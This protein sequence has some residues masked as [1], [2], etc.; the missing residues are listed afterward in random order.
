MAETPPSAS[1]PTTPTKSSALANWLP[2]SRAPT[3]SNEDQTAAEKDKTI[4]LVSDPV[5]RKYAQSVDRSLNAFLDVQEW[6]D[7][8]AFLAKLLKSIQSF[9]QYNEIPHKLIVSKRL[10]QCLNPALPTGVHQKALE[11][12]DKIFIIIGFEGLQRDLQ[13]WSA[14]L[15]PF[16]QYAAMSVRPAVLELYKSHYFPL[17]ANLRSI[18]KSITLSLLPGLEEETGDFFDEVLSMLDYLSNTVSPDYFL[19]NISLILLTSP[20]S[21]IPAL[22]YLIRKM[23]TLSTDEDV[24]FHLNSD[25]NILVRGISSSLIDTDMFVRRSALDLLNSAL[26]INGLILQKYSKKDF[27]VD[28]SRN[29]CN[30]VLRRDISLTRRLYSWLLGSSDVKEVQSEHFEKF[31]LP[32]IRIWMLSDMNSTKSFDSRPYKIFISLL[33]KWEIGNNLTENVITEI[34]RSLKYHLENE[35]DS[36]DVKIITSMVL[37]T[38]DIRLLWKA[39]NEQITVEYGGQ[40]DLFESIDLTSMIIDNISPKD[41]EHARLHFPVQLVNSLNLAYTDQQSENSK[42]SLLEHTLYLTQKLISHIPDDVFGKNA[43]LVKDG[44]H[45]TSDWE[46]IAKAYYTSN[47]HIPQVDTPDTLYEASFRLLILITSSWGQE[48]SDTSAVKVSYDTLYKL[49]HLRKSDKILSGKC[50]ELIS[51]WFE[52]AMKFISISKDFETLKSLIECILIIREAGLEEDEMYLKW[53]NREAH[54]TLLKSLLNHINQENPTN[55]SSVVAL[56]QDIEKTTSRKHISSLLSSRLYDNNLSARMEAVEQF[57]IIYNLVESSDIPVLDVTVPVSKFFSYQTFGNA[58]EMQVNAVW[59]KNNFKSS[60]QLAST[61]IFNVSKV[62]QYMKLVK[63]SDVHGSEVECYE[64]FQNFDQ[65]IVIYSLQQL[66]K[67]S[68]HSGTAFWRQ[69]NTEKQDVLLFEQLLKLLK[70]EPSEIIKETLQPG[71]KDVQMASMRLLIELISNCSMASDKYMAAAITISNYLNYHLHFNN[72]D[73]QPKAIELLT[74][75]LEHFDFND[76]DDVKDLGS[77]VIK[78]LHG[79]ISTASSQM[80]LRHWLDMTVLLVE[81]YPSLIRNHK[82]EAGYIVCDKLGNMLDT[83]DLSENIPSQNDLSSILAALD[84]ILTFNLD[85][86]YSSSSTSHDITIINQTMKL[87]RSTFRRYT[88]LYF[89]LQDRKNNI[90][91]ML[92]AQCQ[93]NIFN[94]FDKRPSEMVDLAV[95]HHHQENNVSALLEL[96]KLFSDKPRLLV[97]IFCR[98]VGLKTFAGHEKPRSMWLSDAVTHLQLFQSLETY[99]DT[100]D[101]KDAL[102]SWVALQPFARESIMSTLTAQ[103][104][105]CIYPT[106]RCLY[107]FGVQVFVAQSSLIIEKRVHQ[108]YQDILQRFVESCILLSS[109]TSDTGTWAL[110]KALAGLDVTNVTGNSDFAD[111]TT[112]K[113]DEVDDNSFN[114]NMIEIHTFI[115]KELLVNISKL[116]T[117][118][119][120]LQSI[121]NNVSYY[122]VAPVLK[123]R[124]KNF[125]STSPLI[126]DMLTEMTKLPHCSRSWR[127]L[128]SDVFYDNKFFTTSASS[129]WKYL[130]NALMST[131]KDKFADLVSRVSSAPSTNIFANREYESLTRALNL[132]RLSFAIYA[133]DP[134]SYMSQLT[135]VKENAI[136]DHQGGIIDQIS[137]LFGNQEKFDGQ[138][139]PQLENTQRQPLLLN[140]KRIESVQ[141]LQPFFS[142]V[143]HV[144]FNNVIDKQ[145]VDWKLLDRTIG[146][147]DNDPDLYGIEY[148]S[149]PSGMHLMESDE[150][151]FTTRD[152]NHG[153][154][155]YRKISSTEEQERGV[156]MFS[157][158]LITSDTYVPYNYLP[159]LEELSLYLMTNPPS[160]DLPVMF[161]APIQSSDYSKIIQQS[162]SPKALAFLLDLLG[163]LL[164]LLFRFLLARK[165]VV[166]FFRPTEGRG[167]GW[168]STAL[169]TLAKILNEVDDGVSN[170]TRTN[171]IGNIGLIDLDRLKDIEGGF[172]ASTTD[173]LLLE[174][175][176]VYDAIIDLSPKVKYPSLYISQKQGNEMLVKRQTYTLGDLYI[177]RQLRS[178]IDSQ[179]LVSS[180]PYGL[181]DLIAD[182]WSSLFGIKNSIHIPSPASSDYH[183]ENED[184]DEDDDEEVRLFGKALNPTPAIT[185]FMKSYSNAILASLL[186]LTLKPDHDY[187][188][189]GNVR[190]DDHTHHNEG[191]EGEED[192]PLELTAK[193]NLEDRAR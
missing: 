168:I 177:W 11:I 166:V 162:P 146:A 46:S 24:I 92:I 105:A 159:E 180:P 68:E 21:R 16:F 193:V 94:L 110:R 128:V 121:A 69:L 120:K 101:V 103:R 57:G 10:S 102:Q 56:M 133:G 5:Y 165:R 78:L 34:I 106:L 9:T 1:T 38:V 19:Q 71:S 104:K 169:D 97:H 136:G 191:E 89:A 72:L 26:S 58:D 150:I 116:I 192:S 75:T 22:N 185:S 66:L 3:I 113:A 182:I 122:I 125:N 14:G 43:S 93:Q 79:A 183:E 70:T 98:N 119:E 13:M 39:M 51:G 124:S 155:I 54:E 74:A 181:I 144:T 12:Y 127:G 158:G 53:M 90:Y 49:I 126:V 154:A 145:E 149:M 96:L 138:F 48:L 31:S 73:V 175:P 147:N 170:Q 167:V 32:L 62:D 36:A 163:P 7:F 50:R 88:K 85:D 23:P 157:V 132:R 59:L 115:A 83:L 129:Q 156:K 6:A 2:R 18:M 37:E 153:I 176:Q 179:T 29:A 164:L 172:V 64:Y 151:Y 161:F 95:E 76:L 187:N 174:K 184:E 67:L 134:G 86:L 171:I 99:L 42:L 148:T 141:D 188:S 100:L 47:E 123:S 4:T 117:T 91:N 45:Y 139:S 111:N 17:R 131:D 84:V 108:D 186:T 44:H 160:D 143:S 152:Y 189:N 142:C 77:S 20:A 109:G 30:V 87:V 63:R 28:L 118:T 40:S 27:Q 8:I 130:V 80:S 25:A 81:D 55:H 35:N 114:E 15:F 173:A 178:R 33:D 52:V 112:S 61:Y 140:V 135:I 65:E 137:Q 41:E 107:K 60:K 82:L 190:D